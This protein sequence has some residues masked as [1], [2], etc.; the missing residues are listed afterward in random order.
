MKFCGDQIRF[1]AV[2]AVGHMGIYLIN[3]LTGKNW[4]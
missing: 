3:H 1:T 4:K 2:L